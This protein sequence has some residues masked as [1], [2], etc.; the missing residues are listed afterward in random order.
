MLINSFNLRIH[1]SETYVDTPRI[2]STARL[3]ELLKGTITDA[4]Y[5]TKLMITE[6]TN[7][8]LRSL[9]CLSNE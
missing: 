8:G 6:I 5:T 9:S 3:I 7:D 1:D 2:I 4:P